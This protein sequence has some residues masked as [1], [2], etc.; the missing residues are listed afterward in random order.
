MAKKKLKSFTVDEAGDN[1]TPTVRK[2]KA[3][4]PE[5]SVEEKEKQPQTTA[6]AKVPAETLQKPVIETKEPSFEPEKVQ[7]V[8]KEF[9]AF[10][11]PHL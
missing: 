7:A 4:I 1:F 8:Q 9:E 11:Q 2:I 6:P 3:D 5:K 10:L